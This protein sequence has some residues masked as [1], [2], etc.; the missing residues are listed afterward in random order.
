M[1]FCDPG[2]VSPPA[3]RDEHHAAVEALLRVVLADRSAAPVPA[4]AATHSARD[5]ID[6]LEQLAAESTPGLGR[7]HRLVFGATADIC[8]AVKLGF[9]EILGQLRDRP[10]RADLA[11]P[12]FGHVAMQDHPAARARDRAAVGG[13]S[14]ARHVLVVDQMHRLLRAALEEQ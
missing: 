10:G 1:Q 8:T 2:D 5:R 11:L 14:L 9:R 12:L 3:V 7:S 13:Y 6:E 4:V